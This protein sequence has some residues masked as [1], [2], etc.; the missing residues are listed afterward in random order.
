MRIIIE[1]INKHSF[2]LRGFTPM[3]SYNVQFNSEVFSGVARLIPFSGVPDAPV[4]TEFEVELAHEAV[5]GFRLCEVS[6]PSVEPLSALG[7][8]KVHGIVRHVT[9]PSAPPGNR[10]TWVHVGKA[11]F[12][13]SVEDT[14]RWRPAV[15]S[16]VEFIVHDLSM[17]DVAL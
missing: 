5:S 2:E 10:I 3:P 13:L 1:D 9:F 7:D 12:V 4:G 14:R 11:D 17:W 8:F 6:S 16:G 15:G